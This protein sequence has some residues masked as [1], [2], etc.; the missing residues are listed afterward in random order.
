MA[1]VNALGVTG[2]ELQ[3]RQDE[4]AAWVAFL[5]TPPVNPAMSVTDGVIS[6]TGTNIV[7]NSRFAFRVAYP[8]PL[9]TIRAR[10]LIAG[11]TSDFTGNDANFGLGAGGQNNGFD[12]SVPSSAYL[13][14][15]LTA[16]EKV[17]GSALDP[18]VTVDEVVVELIPAAEATTQRDFSASFTLEVE[19][20]ATE[21]NFNCE[22][23]DADPEKSLASYR[24]DILI[25]AGF[26]AVADTPPPGVAG[27]IDAFL[28]DAQS[29]LYRKYPALRTR[30]FFRWTMEAGTR[31]YGIRENNDGD[32][33]QTV[34]ISVASPGVVT[35]TAAP[36]NGRK[37]SFS[38][39]DGGSL[40]APL[41]VGVEYYAV[42]RTGT[43]CQLALTPGG[44]PI[45]TTAAGAGVITAH[46]F[47]APGCIF[48]MDPY[49]NIE[50]AW[51]VDLN[52]AWLPLA[53]GIP[54]TFYT[55][56]PQPGLPSRY[57]IRQCIEVFPAPAATGYKLYIK[58]HFGL[59][60][61]ELDGDKPTIDGHLV[62][63]WALA[64]AL[65]YYGKPSAAGI[66]AQ[67]REY[68]G[69][70]VAGT[71]GSRRYIP[72]VRALPPAVMPVFAPFPGETP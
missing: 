11:L 51:L 15:N 16:A 35:W 45:V 19:L 23:E 36:L 24:R 53:E 61:F 66:A 18:L 58:G 55:T 42:A 65:D 2:A 12:L 59:Q 43:T 20:S 27:L 40:P 34:T 69:E 67:A 37:V 25:R 3:W 7:Q 30:R 47:P 29:F 8:G 1:W 39:A 68:L 56:V 60:P 54:P 4:L 62:Y 48:N 63:L 9:G 31:F 57:E 46:G 49:K 10:G 33:R 5:T 14:A 70:L 44:T 38:V 50:G 32:P 71:H 26:A 6:V 13:Q 22:C 28:R 72:G 41:G 64:N 21:T 52:G 17:I